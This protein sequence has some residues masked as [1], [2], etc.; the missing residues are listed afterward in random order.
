MT[1]LEL[2]TRIAIWLLIWGS[3][4]VFCWFGW[5]LLRMSREDG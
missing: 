3:I 2:W 1:A 5:D 4:A